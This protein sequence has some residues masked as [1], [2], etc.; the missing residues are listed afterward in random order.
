VL[1]D[2]GADLVV[3]VL[4]DALPASESWTGVLYAASSLYDRA[5][6]IFNT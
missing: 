3:D 1:V 6:K 2:I 5:L 4:P